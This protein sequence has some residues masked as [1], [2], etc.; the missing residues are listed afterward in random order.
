MESGF[1]FNSQ[2]L[3]QGLYKESDF[4]LK[5]CCLPIGGTVEVLFHL[6][7]LQSRISNRSRER[8]IAAGIKTCKNLLM[9]M[10]H[11]TADGYSL[12]KASWALVVHVKRMCSR[13]FIGKLAAVQVCLSVAR[14]QEVLHELYMNNEIS[15]R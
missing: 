7:Y 9:N 15:Q 11:H 1:A 6:F 4:G 3:S 8:C 14:A 10:A 12:R 5:E 2:S 13:N